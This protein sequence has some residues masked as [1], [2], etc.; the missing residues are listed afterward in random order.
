MSYQRARVP[1]IHR[2]VAGFNTAVRDY[3]L[4]VME[5]ALLVGSADHIDDDDAGAEAVSQ[6]TEVLRCRCAPLP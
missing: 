1:S 4:A 5:Q 2:S 6:A 3:G